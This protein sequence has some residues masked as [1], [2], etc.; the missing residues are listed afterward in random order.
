MTLDQI[1]TVDSMLGQI[2]PVLMEAQNRVELGEQMKRTCQRLRATR[3]WTEEMVNAVRAAMP[4]LWRRAQRGTPGKRSAA[5]TGGWM[6]G[7]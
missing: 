4:G 7:R 1:H 3:G 5:R 6:N 2:E